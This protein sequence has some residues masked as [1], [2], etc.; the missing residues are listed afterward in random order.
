MEISEPDFYYLIRHNK[1][2]VGVHKSKEKYGEHAMLGAYHIEM[3]N[4]ATVETLQEFKAVGRFED[5]DDSI[6]RDYSV[7]IPVDILDKITE[8]SG[9]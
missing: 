1:D 9:S 8:P 7:A 5:G 6:W 3:T 4:Q 2:V